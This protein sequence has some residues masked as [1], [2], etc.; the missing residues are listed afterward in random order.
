[1]LFFKIKGRKT[2]IIPIRSTQQL[3][4]TEEPRRNVRLLS[5]NARFLDLHLLLRHVWI[6]RK[7]LETLSLLGHSLT[8]W[9]SNVKLA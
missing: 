6:P 2:F 8:H 3:Q 9:S 7:S 1:M 5:K 4:K